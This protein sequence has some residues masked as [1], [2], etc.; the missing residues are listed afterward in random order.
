MT[1]K[2]WLTFPHPYGELK[3]HAPHHG[4]RLRTVAAELYSQG[5]LKHNPLFLASS[6]CTVAAW[7]NPYGEPKRRV[8]VNICI[9]IIVAAWLNPYGEL[10]LA[11]PGVRSSDVPGDF[12]LLRKRVSSW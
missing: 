12:V 9:G 8:T 2:I 11:L 4:F 10:K 7:L 1:G 6:F 5:K 3:H